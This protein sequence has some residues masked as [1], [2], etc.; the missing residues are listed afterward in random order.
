[1]QGVAQIEIL[2]KNNQCGCVRNFLRRLS[3]TY[4][5]IRRKTKKRLCL[6]KIFTE[7]INSGLFQK[8]YPCPDGMELSPAASTASA[9]TFS[10]ECRCP[11]R[12]AQSARDGR[13]YELFTAGPCDRGHYFAPDTEYSS[14]AP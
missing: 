14:S 1:M 9:Q 8:G 2:P 7:S 3:R 6:R 4:I 12:T 5:E 13:C 11:P 10:A